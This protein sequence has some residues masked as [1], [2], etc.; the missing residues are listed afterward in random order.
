VAA[1]PDRLGIRAEDGVIGQSG[2]L[3]MFLLAEHVQIVVLRSARFIRLTYGIGAVV[4]RM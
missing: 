1:V 4:R 2:S 3:W